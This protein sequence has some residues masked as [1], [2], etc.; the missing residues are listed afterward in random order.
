MYIY[1]CIYLYTYI[2]T[3]IV[4]CI[5]GYIHRCIYIYWLYIYMLGPPPKTYLFQVSCEKTCLPL[6]PETHFWKC[7]SGPSGKHNFFLYE[8]YI[9]IYI[10]RE[11]ERESERERE[12]APLII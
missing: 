10:E 3:H 6:Q 12:R 7:A 11:R 2:Y 4:L 9:Y 5:D 8:A 1:I